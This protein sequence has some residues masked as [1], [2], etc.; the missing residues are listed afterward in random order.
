MTVLNGQKVLALR[1][2]YF[3]EKPVEEVV[4]KAM[5][6]KATVEIIEELVEELKPVPEPT[7]EEPA[8]IEKQQK[9]AKLEAELAEAKGE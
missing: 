9:I 5:E 6:E 3:K 8:E 1:P 4:S 7:E 2:D